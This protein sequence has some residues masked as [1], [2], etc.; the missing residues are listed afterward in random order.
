[1]R[2]KNPLMRHFVYP[3]RG[4]YFLTPLLAQKKFCKRGN[5]EG[6]LKAFCQLEEDGLGKPLEVTGS[7]GSACASG[8][9][10]L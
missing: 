5:K 10:Y 3:F 7:K 8:N 2:A 4:E 6:T 9:D 1:M